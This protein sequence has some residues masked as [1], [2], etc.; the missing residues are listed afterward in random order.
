[1]Q[2]CVFSQLHRSLAVPI[3]YQLKS[4]AANKARRMRKKK[5]TMTVYVGCMGS[6]KVKEE[7]GT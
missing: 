6:G 1:M 4:K 2:N 5:N 3:I 7:E